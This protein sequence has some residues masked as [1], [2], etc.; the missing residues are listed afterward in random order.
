M[1]LQDFYASFCINN[2]AAV[3]NGDVELDIISDN[4]YTYKTNR[5][6]LLGKLKNRMIKAILI[7]FTGGYGLSQAHLY[8]FFIQ[9]S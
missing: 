4:K 1:V 6:V 8:L 2:I 7:G 3:F 9:N 5:N